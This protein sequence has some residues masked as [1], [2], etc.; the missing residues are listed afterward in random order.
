MTIAKTIVTHSFGMLAW[1]QHPIS[2]VPME[3]TKNKIKTMKSRP[4]EPGSGF[5]QT[6]NH[7][8]L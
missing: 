5:F 2:S 7:G 6:Q 4:T 8:Y 1:H 3:G